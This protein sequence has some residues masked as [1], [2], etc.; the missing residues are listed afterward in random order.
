MPQPHAATSR[1]PHSNVTV[2]GTAGAVA[3]E[4]GG[5]L[6]L[7]LQNDHATNVVYLSLGGTA[8]V[9]KGIRLNAGGGGIMLDWYTGPVSAIA[10][11]AGTT[12]LITEI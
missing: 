4:N 5:R 10:T 6:T 12:L 3:A 1:I 7:I 11:G 2:T 8:E 9:N